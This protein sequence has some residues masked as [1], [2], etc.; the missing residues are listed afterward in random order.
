MTCVISVDDMLPVVLRPT[1]SLEAPLIVESTDDRAAMVAASSHV[2]GACSQAIQNSE[3][4]LE[5]SGDISVGCCAAS[6]LGDQQCAELRVVMAEVNNATSSS[7]LLSDY[8]ASIA[9]GLPTAQRAAV[10][11]SAGVV[12]VAD[13]LMLPV[14][15][16]CGIFNPPDELIATMAR[17]N[18]KSECAGQSLWLAETEADAA[19]LAI[20]CSTIAQNPCIIDTLNACMPS[21]ALQLME[22]STVVAAQSTASERRVFE[23]DG[24]RSLLTGPADLVASVVRAMEA[25]SSGTYDS[26]LLP[27]TTS[28][29]SD[30]CSALMTSCRPA[31]ESLPGVDNLVSQINQTRASPKMC[32]DTVQA[33]PQVTVVQVTL[34]FVQGQFQTVDD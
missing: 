15:E 27:I 8:L 12:T 6:F 5:L 20:T 3:N 33:D 9:P 4:C 17:C 30:E 10:L 14:N 26:Y 32:V 18:S 31:L 34:G 21:S 23:Y 25:I 22:L 29:C 11:E 19:E 7:G 28:I 16:L 1:F 2:C 24:L 13:L